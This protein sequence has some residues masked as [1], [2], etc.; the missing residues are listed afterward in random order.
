MQDNNKGYGYKTASYQYSTT[1]TGGS[2]SYN[3]KS[4]D[5]NIDQ[6]DALLEDLKNEREITRD[7]GKLI[8]I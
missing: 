8:F 5:K 6:L 1:G 4:A 7:R 2:G 3:D